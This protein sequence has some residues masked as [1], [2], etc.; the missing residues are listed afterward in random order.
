[1]GKYH[2][3]CETCEDETITHGWTPEQCPFCELAKFREQ[4]RK[5]N[6][7]HKFYYYEYTDDGG[8]TWTFG[9]YRRYLMHI[10]ELANAQPYPFRVINQNDI[11]VDPASIKEILKTIESMKV[12]LNS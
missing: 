9:D 10:V 11:E 5:F 2:E 8:K 12:L 1:M 4:Q 3:I 7:K 6:M